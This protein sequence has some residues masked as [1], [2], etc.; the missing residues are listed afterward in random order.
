MSLGHHLSQGGEDVGGCL[1][2]DVLVLGKVV[3]PVLHL[4]RGDSVL[5][6]VPELLHDV[7]GEDVP[8][9][10]VVL[11]TVGPALLQL[12]V[13]VRAPWGILSLG[14]V[15]PVLEVL[16]EQTGVAGF[17]KLAGL[18]GMRAFSRIS[19]WQYCL[20]SIRLAQ[21]VDHLPMTVQSS[22]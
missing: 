2:E 14:S 12:L 11:A 18:E 20:A 1:V 5:G 3:V 7:L 13:A 8:L 22:E 10:G 17:R 15:V 21:R 9:N 19:R 16:G 4:G 6:P